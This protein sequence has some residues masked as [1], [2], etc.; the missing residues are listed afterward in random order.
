MLDDV[1]AGNRAGCRT[2][3]VDLG[4]EGPPTSPCRTPTAVARHTRQALSIV[5]A[6][7]GL[8]VFA[9]LGYRPQAW[10]R[11]ALAEALREYALGEAAL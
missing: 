7:S 8:D 6:L 1:E 11:P 10:G 4:T 3:L 5:A 2:V 9:E